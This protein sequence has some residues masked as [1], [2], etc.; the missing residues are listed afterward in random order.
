MFAKN[1]NG[2]FHFSAVTC[3]AKLIAVGLTFQY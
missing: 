3:T 1:K 2:A